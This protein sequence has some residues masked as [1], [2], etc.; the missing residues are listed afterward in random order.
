VRE[1]NRTLH[2]LDSAATVADELLSLEQD[3]TR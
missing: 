2:A 1:R 3:G